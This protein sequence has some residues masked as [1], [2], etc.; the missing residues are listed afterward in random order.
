MHRSV[1]HAAT[2]TKNKEVPRRGLRARSRVRAA[3]AVG[4]LSKR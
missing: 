2:A 4:M 3:A 1:A